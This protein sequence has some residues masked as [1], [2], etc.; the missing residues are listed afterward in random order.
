MKSLGPFLPN[1][2]KNTVYTH[3]SPENI[4]E[5]GQE[6]QKMLSAATFLQNSVIP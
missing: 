3:F 6:E 1:H 5:K 2:T 4:L